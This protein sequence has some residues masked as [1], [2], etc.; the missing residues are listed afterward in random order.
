MMKSSLFDIL[1]SHTWGA[2]TEEVTFSRLDKM[3]LARQDQVATRR[4]G[5][6]KNKLDTETNGQIFQEGQYLMN[7]LV[8]LIVN[9]TKMCAGWP[10]LFKAGINLNS[11]ML[12]KAPSIGQ[13]IERNHSL[14]NTHYRPASCG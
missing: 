1:L 3:A 6:A 12:R 14:R 5:S 2:A 11:Q 7:S 8:P 9:V 10:S 4:S 13:A